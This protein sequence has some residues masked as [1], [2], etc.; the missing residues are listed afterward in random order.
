[1]QKARVNFCIALYLLNL[2]NYFDSNLSVI[3]KLN[4]LKSLI[5]LF[6]NYL[7]LIPINFIYKKKIRIHLK[8]L[9]CYPKLCLKNRIGI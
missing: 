7:K 6:H 2:I 4:F 3:K 5:C 9:L 8:I 1:M